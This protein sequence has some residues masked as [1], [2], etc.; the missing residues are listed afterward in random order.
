MR[1]LLL[2][3]LNE[4]S[5]TSLKLSRR[6]VDGV[7]VLEGKNYCWYSFQVKRRTALWD[8]LFYYFNRRERLIAI[9]INSYLGQLDLWKK[10]A[11]VNASGSAIPWTSRMVIHPEIISSL[12]EQR[13]KMID[14]LES[15]PVI[16][17]SQATGHWQ[18]KEGIARWSLRY[19]RWLRQYMQ[20]R[21]P[22]NI[23]EIPP[24]AYIEINSR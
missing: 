22:M 2:L 13:D 19:R 21:T 9:L 7:F 23:G 20:S 16:H 17:I 14:R 8:F 12:L 10:A 11:A 4:L 15:A 5:D 1:Q 18:R 3:K 24:P 6:S